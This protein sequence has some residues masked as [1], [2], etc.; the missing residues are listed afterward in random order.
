MN[1]SNDAWFGGYSSGSLLAIEQNI[2]IPECNTLSLMLDYKTI[3]CLNTNDIEL[4]VYINNSS[5]ATV[6][7]SKAT[8]G[9]VA[10]FGPV[11][12]PITSA[13]TGNSL[14]RFEAIETGTNGASIIIDNISLLSKDCPVSPPCSQQITASYNCQCISNL[15][16]TGTENN[17]VE[18]KAEN[19]ISTSTINANVT[20]QA[21]ESIRLGIGFNTNTNFNFSAKIGNCN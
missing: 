11:D 20:Y 2:K 6:N 19:I 5:V 8:N 4:S 13:I 9:G 15:N 16:L 17:D 1:G 14:I 18:Y 3:N 12:I 21:V 10:T 7:C